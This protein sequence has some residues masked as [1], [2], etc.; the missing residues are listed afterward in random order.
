MRKIPTSKSEAIAITAKRQA[1]I[2][3]GTEA[4]LQSLCVRSFAEKYPEKRGRLWANFSNPKIEQYN[5]WL[6]MGF[7]E[8]TSDLLYTDD[9]KRLVA[10]ECKHPEMLHKI[11]HVKKQ[12]NWIINNC[13]SGGFFTSVEM[14]FDIIEGRNNGI[15]PRR[16]LEHISEMEKFS[17][18]R[19]VMFK[20]LLDL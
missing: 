10:L 6:S 4:L 18:K 7:V 5:T 12:A 1:K 11:D 19:T 15:D 14:F 3:L 16:V 9:W 20:D 2:I 8:G 13:H 17:K